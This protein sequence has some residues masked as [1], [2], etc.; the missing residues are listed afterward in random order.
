MDPIS[1]MNSLITESFNSVK[2][3]QSEVLE[4]LATTTRKVFKEITQTTPN[5]RQKLSEIANDATCA[6]YVGHVVSNRHTPAELLQSQATDDFVQ[7]KE[8]EC[9][10]T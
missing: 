10:L 3:S 2:E 4:T 5:W 7:G 9:F 8:S 6:N 1:R